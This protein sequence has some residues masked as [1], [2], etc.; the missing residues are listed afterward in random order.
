MS[1]TYQDIRKVYQDA[2]KLDIF[3]KKISDLVALIKRQTTYNDDE[4]KN[5]LIEHNLDVKQILKLYN[6]PNAQT[7]KNEPT[8]NNQ[9]MFKVYRDFLD[10]ASR[11]FY[12]NRQH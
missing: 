3:E 2:D 7:H 9:K 6:D 4:A 8:T 10:D 12:E 5:L 1:K 11:K